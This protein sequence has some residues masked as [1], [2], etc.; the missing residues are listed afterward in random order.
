[1]SG[2]RIGEK[3]PRIGSG[4]LAALFLATLLAV[5]ATAGCEAP[6]AAQTPV[7]PLRIGLMITPQG[8]NDQGFND[9]A[10][11][12][13]KAAQKKYGI[14]SVIIEPATMKDPEASLRFFAAQ[15]FDA[16][17]VVG[18]AFQRAIQKI[19]AEHPEL[20]FF[21]V[22]SDYDEGNIHGI[23]FREHEGSFLC[24]VILE[25]PQDRLYRWP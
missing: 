22:D 8:L 19:S 25:D 14:E 5:L 12:G 1:M 23:V 6:K 2:T 17:I 24:G 15:P 10:Y 18:M 11:E 20:K 21:A 13:I 4:L 9:Q 7:K 3:R 16:I